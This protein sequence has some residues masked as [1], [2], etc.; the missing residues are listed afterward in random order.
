MMEVAKRFRGRVGVVLHIGDSITYANPYGQWARWGKGKTK[1]DQAAL[2]WMHTGA[3]NDTDGWWLA[4]FDHPDG[5]RSY[6]A[7]SGIRADE[8]LRGGK[9]GLPPL[10]TL[11]DRYKP[12]IVVLMLGTNDASARRSVK[13]Y[14]ADME[15]CVDEILK[16]GVICILSTIPPHCH[17]PRLAEAYNKAIRGNR[18]GKPANFADALS[19]GAPEAVAILRSSLA[20]LVPV[21]SELSSFLRPETIVFSA[22]IPESAALVF[23]TVMKEGF[24]ENCPEIVLTDSFSTAAG[25][26]A[27]G[28]LWMSGNPHYKA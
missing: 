26:A 5:G 2:T 6:T 13:A 3:N 15:R 1:E 11:L 21:L 24:N 25:A 9:H 23:S 16:R 7:C 28:T 19:V 4:A 18:E 12:Q 17:Q 10:T 14:R 22:D 8:M 20:H 27:L